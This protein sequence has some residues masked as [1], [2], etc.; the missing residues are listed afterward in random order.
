MIY[1]IINLLN[2]AFCALLEEHIKNWCRLCTFD[3]YLLCGCIEGA[4]NRA[5]CDIMK[6][7]CSFG[8]LVLDI[9]HGLWS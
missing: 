3:T 8:I 4:I 7:H 5:I 2:L 6:D 1:L 9:F